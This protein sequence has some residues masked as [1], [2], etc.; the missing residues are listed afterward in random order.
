MIYSENPAQE[1]VTSHDFTFF[2]TMSN[3]HDPRKVEA[4]VHDTARRLSEAVDAVLSR[5]TQ[6][7]DSFG[8]AERRLISNM[9]VF[10]SLKEQMKDVCSVLSKYGIS[11]QWIHD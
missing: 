10:D 11:L 1:T 8:A 2:G 9:T 3:D 6:M 4:L 7:T 5:T